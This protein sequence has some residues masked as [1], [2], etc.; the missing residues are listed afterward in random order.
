MGK[1]L[2]VR[3]RMLA[4]L[5]PHVA[6]ELWSLLGGK[7]FVSIAS[8]PEPD[9]R[10]Q[11]A[12]AESSEN[13]VRQVMEDTV[14]IM[15]ATGI[16]PKTIAYYTAPDWKWK[17]YMKALEFAGSEPNP[18]KV[19]D[20]IKTIMADPEIRSE[21]KL[22]ADY[23]NKSFQQ[24]RQLQQ[25]RASRAK[26]GRVEEARILEEA[27]DFFQREFHSDVQVWKSGTEDVDDP[28]GKAKTAEPY[29]PAIYLEE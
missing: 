28:K 16:K 13:L 10:L 23:A 8:W 21:G 2:E 3:T 1:I 9:D 27:K 22:A 25:L 15:K 17:T 7:R 5:A 19:G 20:F 26:T 24:A 14:E 4:P 18:S 11:Y 6:E 12:E 29:R